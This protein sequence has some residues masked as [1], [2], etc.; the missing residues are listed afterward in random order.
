MPNSTHCT[1]EDCDSWVRNDPPKDFGWTTDKWGNANC[2][3]HHQVAAA[4]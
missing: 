4:V 3:A 2:G 1:V